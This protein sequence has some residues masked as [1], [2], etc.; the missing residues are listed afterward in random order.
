MRSKTNQGFTHQQIQVFTDWILT[1]RKPFDNL[2]LPV[3]PQKEI[4]TE[5]ILCQWKFDQ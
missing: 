5:S 2:N 4:E 1:Q 3:I